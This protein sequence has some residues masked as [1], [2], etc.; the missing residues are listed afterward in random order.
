MSTPTSRGRRPGETNTREVIAEAART[1]FAQKGYRATT[2]R[3]IADAAEVDAALVSH[4]YGNKATLFSKVVA[5]PRDAEEIV[6]EVCGG[7]QE[8]VGQRLA[9]VIARNMF[10]D[11]IVLNMA[12]MVRAATSEED[13]ADFLRERFLADIL[14]PIAVG[15]SPDSP[16]KRASLVM[17]QSNGL[18]FARLILEIEPL[19]SMGE[20]ELVAWLA[21]VFQHYLM[22]DV[23]A[24]KAE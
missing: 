23:T 9:I 3:A 15:V 19:A 21:P 16:E 22:G 18:V 4:F 17:S 2:L 14:L 5:F 6:A 7:P 8:S 1:L 24:S 12:S 10:L 11:S 13:A 20:E